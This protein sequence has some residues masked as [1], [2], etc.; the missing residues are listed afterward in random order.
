[1]KI[2]YILSDTTKSATSLALKEVIKRAETDK[3]GNFV[4]LVPE[5]KSIIIEKE[6]LSLSE[7]HAFANIFV[8]SFVRLINRLG[9]VASEKIVT[10]QTCVM[11]LRKI[12]FEN[13]NQ[14]KTYKKTAKTIGF[15]EKIY[16]T[17]QQFK[18]SNVSVFD[19]KE[20]IGELSG[21][22]KAKLSDIV[23]LYEEYEKVLEGKFF[24]D[25][26][27]LNLLND[28]AKTSEFLKS[29]EIFVV[30]FDNVTYEMVS[31]L[32]NL[33]INSKETTFSCCYFNEKRSDKHIQNN[34]LFKK[35]KL[36]SEELKFPYVPK[37]SEKQAKGD[38]LALK[39]HLFSTE[40]HE[41]E[42]KGNVC[43][44]EAKSKKH[45]IDFVANQILN[46]I[47]KGKRFKDIGLVVCGLDEN[48]NIIEDCFKSY[49]IP[50]FVNKDYKISNHALIK[51]V[52]DC[53][54]LKLSHLSSEKVLKFLSN[55]FVDCDC[56]AVFENFVKETGLNYGAFLE[57][58]DVNSFASKE[59][60]LKI[61]SV[62]KK[63]QAFYKL[64]DAEFQNAKTVSD[65][66]KSLTFAI[67]FFDVKT[68]LQK[69]AEFQKNNGLVVESEISSAIFDKFEEFNTSFES[70]MGGMNV[71]I[72]EF[73]QIYLNG[74]NSIKL[75][76]SPVSIDCVIVQDNTD[77]FFEIK[78]LFVFGAEEG[79]FPAKIQ[80]AGV[81]LDSELEETKNA[82][83]KP[84]EPTVKEINSRE[85]FRCY[86]TLLE[87]CENLW[88]TYSKKGFD[89]SQTKPSRVVMRVLSL[90]GENIKKTTFKRFNKPIKTGSELVFAKNI[91]RFFDGE[92]LISDLNKQFN[93]IFDELS[94]PF[95]KQILNLNNSEPEFVEP[96]AKDL[97]FLN[98]TTSI[99][100][101]EKYFMCPYLF[102]ATY[103]LRLKENKEA[104]LSSLDIGSIVHRVAELFIKNISK[105][106]AEDVL[107]EKK[108]EAL[109]ED[110]YV[111]FKINKKQNKAIL[112]FVTNESKRLCKHLFFEQQNSSFKNK[113][114][115][116]EYSFSGENAVKLSLSDNH[117]I[118][119]EGKIDRIDEWG[120]YIRIIDY[121]TGDIKSDLSAVYYGKKIQ[122]VSYLLAAEKFNGK[123]VAG[124]FYFPIHSE[125]VKND[126][127]IE[128]IYKL[129]GFLIDD[130]NVL[131][132]MDS[133]VSFEKP[134]SSF[135]PFKIKTSKEFVNTNTFEINKGRQKIY[136]SNEQFEDL[137]AYNKKLCEKAVDEILTGFIEPSPLTAGDEPFCKW[138][139]ISGFC[140]VEKSR[141]KNGR[142]F[143]GQVS[144]DSFK[145][146]SEVSHDEW[147]NH[148]S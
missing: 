77:G 80:D 45:E 32:K 57:N 34:D 118:L 122:L 85:L 87:P 129:Q 131:K 121:K 143:V 148:S 9:Y 79:K 73:L 93:M 12:I 147:K 29:S 124:L 81:I 13:L 125:F 86:E 46:E 38:F 99:S 104:K 61:E 141:F 10:K 20:K 68:K 19:L 71:S 74:F 56:Y 6:L 127:K 103:G 14:I 63:F 54:E 130:A 97:Y 58:I 44:F 23:F 53:F 62:L 96:S 75:N 142:K 132:H 30:G 22:L 136:F 43:V 106:D 52:S 76:I 24:D 109:C 114:E 145:Q 41:F 49:E 83:L 18:S 102:F 115:L 27:R 70:F 128:D 51:F 137:K 82:I 107:F 105:F 144:I 112:T 123:K 28:F 11:L 33:A 60:A 26:D 111:E 69:I 120:D 42:S 7:N 101:L 65:C 135:V 5:T 94:E 146:E 126:K 84:I 59:N 50:Y 35:F 3:F 91:G 100:Q 134:E 92:M 90:F 89:G 64:F 66:L 116:N 15:A 113:K 138:C 95:K 39:N 88:L 139:P 108:V 36:V 2:N 140:D 117:E 4:V 119:I 1:M 47:E 21:S 37:F 133:G 16:D 55:A 110:V 78:D 17:I 40:K 67:N 25:C 31:V 48:I 98:N 8:Y 72:D